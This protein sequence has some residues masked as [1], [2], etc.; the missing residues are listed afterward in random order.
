MPQIVKDIQYLMEIE[1]EEQIEIESMSLW[2]EKA[3]KV[4][5]GVNYSEE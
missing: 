2:D 3:E 5:Y 1:A 4:E